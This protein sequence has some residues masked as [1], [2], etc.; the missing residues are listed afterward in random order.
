MMEDNRTKKVIE[1]C[2]SHVQNGC[3]EVCPLSSACVYKAGDT[4]EIFD[5]RINECAENI[6]FNKVEK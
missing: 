3:R 5:K 1:I 4:K 2:C 6:N